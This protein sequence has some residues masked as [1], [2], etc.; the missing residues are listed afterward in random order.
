M[1]AIQPI[2]KECI[3]EGKAKKIFATDDTNKII[4]YYKDDAT[5]FNA[6]KKGTIENKGILNN[7]I[8][9]IIY[10]LL[11]KNGITTHFIERLNDREQWCKKVTIIPLEIIV[12][13]RIAGSMA[14]LFKIEEGTV[15]LQP[16]FEICYKNDA[17]GDP[18][19]NDSHAIALGFATKEELS[20]I[21]QTA[22]KL[23]QILSAFF[24]KRD[25][26]LVDFKIEMGKTN[27]GAFI[28][29]DEISPDTCRL[30]DAKTLEKLDKDRFRRDLGKVEEAYQEIYKRINL[31]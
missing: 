15:P 7:K 23:N 28:L 13:N 4:V 20:I 5:A 12:R 10:R 25:I 26:L 11:E 27:D 21:Y 1:A 8:T 30:W 3:Y 31:L 16:I 19:I 9:E 2:K 29:A 6:Q 24:L 22:E 18:M 14:K 17:L